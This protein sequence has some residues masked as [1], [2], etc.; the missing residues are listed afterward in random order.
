V[1]IDVPPVYVNEE[2]RAG[3]LAAR[4]TFLTWAKGSICR[5]QVV[6]FSVHK[7]LKDNEFTVCQDTTKAL[8]SRAQEE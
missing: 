7:F 3:R 5:S 8:R 6:I 1:Q 4:A 2:P